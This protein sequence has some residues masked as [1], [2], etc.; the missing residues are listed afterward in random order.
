MALTVSALIQY[1][2]KSLAG[3]TLDT[4]VV[5]PRGL[6]GDRR[7]MLVDSEGQ[8]VTARTEPRLLAVSAALD[9][10]CLTLTGPDGDSVVA[11]TL[12][13]FTVEVAIWGDHVA[14]YPVSGP[15]NAWLSAY[16]GREITLFRMTDDVI[17][18]V[19][20]RAGDIVSF[21]DAYPLLITTEASRADVS[22]KAGEDIAMARFRP[23]IVLTGG[24]AYAE[25]DWQTL[26]IGGVVF[27]IVSPCERCILTTTDPVTQGRHPRSE[28]LRTLA[29]YRRS[30]AGKAIFGVNAVPRGTGTIRVGDLAVAA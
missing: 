9:G 26:T 21:A 16:L 29:T 8:F 1:P 5:Q 20:D 25:D 23:N 14:A 27:D 19:K 13:D 15:V 7:F 4:T 10:A 11:E 17:R 12:S 2:V 18:P 3:N 24:L 30:A 22:A 6:A 28:P